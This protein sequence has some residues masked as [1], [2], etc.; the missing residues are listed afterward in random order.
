MNYIV[1]D[2]EWNQSNQSTQNTFDNK[3]LLFEII[4]IG[5]IKLDEQFHMLGE[6]SE[7]IKPQ[8]F[9]EMHHITSK[10][11][12]LQ[13]KELQKGQPFSKVIQDFLTWCGEDYI[14]CTWGPLD[15]TELQKNMKY[16]G[17][18]PLSD[19]PIAFYD[20]QKLF[21]IAFEDRKTRRALEFAVDYLE[22]EKDIPFHRAFSDAYYT[23][24]VLAKIQN[25]EVFENYSY[26]TFWAPPTKK[27]E[28]FVIFDTYAKYISRGFETKTNAMA[29]R[30]IS[31][32]KCYLCDRPLRKKI[33][34][35]SPN[36][37]NYYCGAYCDKHGFMK[38]KMRVR[39]DCEDK[40]FVIKTMKYIDKEGMDAL[41]EKF[42]KTKEMKKRR[43]K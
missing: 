22:V 30:E 43:R 24:K 40:V 11:I 34:W 13:M 23:A 1:L 28:I 32:I 17:V 25:E 9:S 10:L 4:E 2:L 38:A 29:D 7:L 5:A 19:K 20:V 33:R 3:E 6:F 8:V 18:E 16:F 41:Q 26:D 15:L 35:F 37:K 21:S 27:E 36:N 42:I 31:T 12:H 39:K 14:F